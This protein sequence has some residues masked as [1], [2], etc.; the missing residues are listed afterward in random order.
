MTAFRH[1]EPV[2]L[3]DRD[4]KSHVNGLPDCLDRGLN[5]VGESRIRAESVDEL[6]SRIRVK[7]I[8]Y[9]KTWQKI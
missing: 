8:I 6:T 4:R 1:L 7:W 5:R 3:R 9:N 2:T